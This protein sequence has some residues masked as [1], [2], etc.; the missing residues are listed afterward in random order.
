[1]S[2]SD[3]VSVKIDGQSID[4]P[5]GTLIIRAAEKLG[6]HIPRFCDHPLLDPVGACRQ[7]LV[8]VAM[9]NRAGE[10]A[11][12][13]KPQPACTMTV[14]PQMEVFT[15][16]TSPVAKKAQNGIMEFLLINHPLDCPICDKGGECPLQNQALSHGQ[17]ESRFGEAKRT[18][19]KPVSLSS[20][21]LLDR[22]RCILCQ[23]CVRF[24]Q[25][26]AGDPFIALQ[27][28]GGGSSPLDHHHFTGEQIGRFD[29]QTLG[30][31][32]EA[33]KTAQCTDM[34]GPSGQAGYA[35]G[36]HEGPV[37]PAMEDLSGRRFS[38]YFAGNIIQICPVGALT[39]AT[40]RFRARPFDLVS[41]GAVTE[42]DASGAKIR[43]DVRR[44]HITRRMAATD[45]EVNEEWISDK[46]RFAFQWQFTDQ[47]LK[48]PQVRVDGKLVSTSWE[49]ALDVAAKGLAKATSVGL[50]P[51][52]R[53]AFEDAYAWS[54]FARVA[55]G[56]NN[57]DFRAR[58][59]SDEESQF[60][61]SVVA[62]SGLNVTYNDL[63]NA[64][65]VLLV[66]LEPE[67]ECATLFLRLRKASRAGTQIATIAP[68]ATVGTQKMAATLIPAAPGTEV[69]IL[70]SIA[71]GSDVEMLAELAG[72]LGENGIVL[73]GERAAR[74]P[75]V[76]SAVTRLAARTN[77][78]LAWVPRRSGDRAGVEAGLLPNLLPFGRPLDQGVDLT[79]KWGQTP[80]E[81]GLGA[82]EMLKAHLDALVIGG[83]DVRDLPVDLTEI[84]QA[85][86][87]VALEVNQTAITEVADVVFPVAP[88]AEKAGTFIN[89]E[90][91]LAPFAQALSTRA[92]SDREV[93][94]EIAAELNKPL[95]L[96]TL[97]DVHAE[98][99]EL[100]DYSGEKVT[101]P[102][103]AA[104]ELTAPPA[105]SAVLATHKPL[106]DEG[107]MQAGNPA[108]TGAGRKPVVVLGKEWNI[109]EGA[110]VTVS[111]D[112]G[113]ITLPA[114]IANIVE[115]VVWLPECSAG[116][117]VLASLGATSGT[118]VRVAA[119]GEVN[120]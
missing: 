30:F 16:R 103:T 115:R 118:Q 52:G 6:I 3:L 109:A 57:V 44:G 90:G 38:S 31:E 65:Q 54:K 49:D 88:V 15:Q 56:T 25:Q 21:I 119:K 63:Q 12:M 71:G 92:L 37:T 91:R 69:E 53:L 24:Q 48:M 101:A 111:T 95:G 59:H 5:K 94:G 110:E 36:F 100:M 29:S 8:E 98:A 34:S 87:I 75:G 33:A 104:S 82:T 7:C 19:P 4:V 70:D 32:D 64:G 72:K 35:Q 89:W 39:S 1:M 96:Q 45:M 20:T 62:G 117:H 14:A 13:P 11:K 42:H 51:G 73:V 76:L 66:A 2:T 78:R 61:A 116:S 50:L 105:G 99:N 47:R 18:F 27:G 58:I 22:D 84:R 86:F 97:A 107:L 43:N 93:L 77:A 68:F 112:A 83:V 85:G 102:A 79:E 81:P 28:R 60:L 41:T 120:R 114:H 26:I 108:L 106:L 113:E 55:L 67:D 9:P 10:V 74:I 17:E 23:R 46:D 80:T 40:Y